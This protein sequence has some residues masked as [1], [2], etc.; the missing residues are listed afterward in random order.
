MG[1]PP[2]M[3]TYP[4][5]SMVRP[6][7]PVRSSNVL[8]TS[9]DITGRRWTMSPLG[10]PHTRLMS[11]TKSNCLLFPSRLS[12]RK[13]G[14][15]GAPMMPMVRPGFPATGA[16]PGAPVG[17]SFIHTDYSFTHTVKEYYVLK[18]IVSADVSWSGPESQKASTAEERSG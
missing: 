2:F 18:V 8:E 12:L 16:A 17:L 14:A 7:S 3:G 5:F 4:S 15:P 10:V 9:L 1:V 11:G 13:P 6:P